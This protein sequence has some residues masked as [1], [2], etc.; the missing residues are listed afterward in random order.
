MCQPD[1]VPL[2]NARD[3]AGAV[4]PERR[5]PA[6]GVRRPQ[7]P[8][9]H[10]DPLRRV[11]D[12]G[13]N[14]GKRDEVS[15]GS[16]GAPAVRQPNLGP[17]MPPLL[18]RPDHVEVRGERSGQERPRGREVRVTVEI[19]EA[20]RDLVRRPVPCLRVPDQR[21]LIDPP[22]GPARAPDLREAQSLLERL[23]RLAQD[24]LVVYLRGGIGPDVHVLDRARDDR[25]PTRSVRMQRCGDEHRAKEKDDAE[26]PDSCTSGHERF[27]PIWP[28]P[29][30][31]LSM[32]RPSAARGARP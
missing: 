28:P 17:G 30:W 27:S 1:A 14:L 32:K 7:E 5:R 21:P 23:H 31:R 22:H 2:Q 8:L 26:S 24:H 11:R 19:R 13:P 6:P 10:L 20:G 3:E 9:R 25:V 16:K 4:E 15:A 18:K 12:D 29:T